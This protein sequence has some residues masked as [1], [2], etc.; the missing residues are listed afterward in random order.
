MVVEVTGVRSWRALLPGSRGRGRGVRQE[1]PEQNRSP[2]KARP[3][4]SLW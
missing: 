1:T 4:S 3:S 2:A